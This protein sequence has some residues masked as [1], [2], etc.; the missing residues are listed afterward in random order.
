M[1]SSAEVA[2]TNTSSSKRLAQINQ[3]QQRG[4]I[5]VSAND[6]SSSW[7]GRSPGHWLCR[8]LMDRNA[9]RVPEVQ[10]PPMRPGR[11]AKFPPRGNDQRSTPRIAKR[12]VMKSSQ[13]RNFAA[14]GD[15]GCHEHA[16]PN[17]IAR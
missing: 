10:A 6:Q 17:T 16:A 12:S 11:S 7:R 5:G 14:N 2:S 3:A 4:K 8:Q 13:R 9:I 15:L 1:T